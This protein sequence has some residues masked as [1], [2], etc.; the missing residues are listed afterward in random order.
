MYFRRPRLIVKLISAALILVVVAFGVSFGYLI[1][2]SFSLVS[3]SVNLSSS[4][5]GY[6][7]ISLLAAFFVLMLYGGAYVFTSA[8]RHP[9]VEVDFIEVD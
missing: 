4:F 8:L 7:Y 6:E 5:T 3:T 9:T 1:Y 2:Q